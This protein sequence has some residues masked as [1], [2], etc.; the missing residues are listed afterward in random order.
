MFGADYWEFLIWRRLLD[1]FIDEKC[2]Q[3]DCKVV[4]S[5]AREAHLLEKHNIQIR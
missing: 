5:T 4:G 1:Y 3:C 2:T